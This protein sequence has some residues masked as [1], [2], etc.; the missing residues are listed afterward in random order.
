MNVGPDYLPSVVQAERRA[1]GGTQQSAGKIDGAAVRVPEHR[2][3]NVEGPGVASRLTEIVQ[4]ARSSRVTAG[5]TQVEVGLRAVSPDERCDHRAVSVDEHLTARVDRCGGALACA[6][7]SA[8]EDGPHGRVTP[9][10]VRINRSAYDLACVV[11]G[12]HGGKRRRR[13]QV[14]ENAGLPEEHVRVVEVVAERSRNLSGFI[15]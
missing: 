8:A 7:A 13:R 5:S 14:R 3:R 12:A 6:E 9:V 11:Q 10:V 4:G 15:D 2:A 1:A